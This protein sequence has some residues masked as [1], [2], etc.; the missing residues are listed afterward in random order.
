MAYNR[1]YIL[2]IT[3]ITR[4]GK[5]RGKSIVIRDLLTIHFDVKR[6]PMMGDSSATIDIYNLQPSTR[7]KLFLDYFD[8]QN[9]QQVTLEA[10][11]QNGRFDLIYKGRVVTCRTRHEHTENI[12]RIEAQSGLLVLDSYIATSMNDGKFTTEVAREAANQITGLDSQFF[13]TEAITIPRPVALMGN[14]M[15]VLQTYTKGEA[16][17]DNEK[18][19][20][21]G[22]N[23]CVDGDIRVIDDETGLLGAPEREQV[24]LTVSCIFEPRIKVG[25]G[26]EIKSRIAPEFDGQYK[27]WGVSHSGVLGVAASG[28]CTTKIQ[29][30]TGLNIFG[31]FRTTNFAEAQEQFKGLVKWGGQE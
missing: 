25:Q 23:Q 15:A 19:I 22:E 4:D 5:K 2:T 14:E 27:V 21:L 6:M 30:W 1:K 12:T 29:L 16:F 31:R 7:E 13:T 9:I 8:F 10:G 20:V 11:Y 18:V 3:P 28:Q 24:T 26:I 17:V